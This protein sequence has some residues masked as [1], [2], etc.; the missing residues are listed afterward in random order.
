VGV[1][2]LVLASV[3]ILVGFLAKRPEGLALGA[4]GVVLVLV[5]YAAPVTH[6][7]GSLPFLNQVNWLRALMPLCLVVAALAGI[8]IDAM[9]SP[10]QYRLLRMWPLAGFITALVF[11]GA[12]WFFGRNG[13]LP[14]F[15]TNVARHVRAESFVWPIVGIAVGLVVSVVV[16]RGPRLK[17]LGGIVLLLAEIAFLL[18]AGSSLISSSTNGAQPTQAVVALRSVVGS[19]RVGTGRVLGGVCD[20]GITPEANIFFGIRELN[21]YDAVIPKASFSEWERVTHGSAGSVAFVHFCPD[22]RTVGEARM[23]G[24]GYVLEPAG[25]PGPEG[26]RFVERIFV[27]DPYPKND[28]LSAPPPNEDLYSVPNARVATLST[29]PD[30]RPGPASATLKTS[31]SDPASLSVTTRGAR[32]GILRVRVTNVPGWR[33]TID[34]RPLTLENSSVFE[35][36]AHIPAGTHHVQFRY[37]PRLFTSGLA[38]ALVALIA[39]GGAMALERRRKRGARRYGDRSNP[40]DSEPRGADV[41]RAQ[42]S[43]ETQPVAHAGP[44]WS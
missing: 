35:L 33:A 11:V 23:L 29:G 21:I 31:E 25:V 28:L 7:I 43:R 24:V 9:M 38:I 5:V 30:G 19:T 39:L 15:G 37:W 41:P 34:G 27:A 14:N 40:R 17:S 13:G 36:Q 8:G 4:V 32:T 1:I 10:T 3:G 20:L 12:L 16:L 44:S 22:I 2:A 42:V 26:S 18:S 6:L